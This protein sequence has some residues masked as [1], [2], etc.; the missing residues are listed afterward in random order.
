MAFDEVVFPANLTEA[1]VGG[2]AFSTIVIRTDSGQEQRIAR[3]QRQLGQWK[4]DCSTL[5][6]DDLQDLVAFF[7][8]R[9]GRLRGFR[10]K[11]WDDYEAVDA[12]QTVYDTDKIQ[13]YK[14]Y[15]S[16]GI[17]F[18]RKIVKPVAGTVTLERNGAAYTDFTVSTATGIATLTGAK[19]G[20]FTASFEFDIPVRFD[21]DRLEASAQDNV[22]AWNS[23]PIVELLI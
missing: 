14:S 12:P 4:L 21:T 6:A 2:P 23:V 11:D 7:L 1:A 9:Q 20:V 19:D 3:W 17:T 16:G 18:Q 15:S 5:S 22:R 10:M 8:A 13:L